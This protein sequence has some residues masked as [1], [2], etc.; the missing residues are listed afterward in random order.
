MHARFQ[1][2]CK[3]DSY[4]KSFRMV[5]C[6]ICDAFDLQSFSLYDKQLEKGYP[7]RSVERSAQAGCEFCSFLKLH[8]SEQ[9][10]KVNT[11]RWAEKAWIHFRMIPG[12]E[13]LGSKPLGLQYTHL[14]A[15][16]A[17]FDYSRKTW[18]GQH[19]PTKYFA[20]I[21]DPGMIVEFLR[22]FSLTQLR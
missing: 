3:Q 2:Y 9:I 12:G 4:L 19:P 7:V 15:Y 5:L 21:A 1:K 18:H 13:L 6:Q 20:L 8:L 10:R 14:A 16:V 11:T 22:I 17:A